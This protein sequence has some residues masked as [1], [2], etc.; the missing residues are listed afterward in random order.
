MKQRIYVVS[1]SVGETCELVVRAAAIQFPEQAFE[2]VRIPFVDDEQVIFDLVLH[3]KEERAT[4]VYT[5][6][7]AVHRKVLEETARAHHVEAIDVLGPLLDSMETRLGLQP[8]EEPG[9]IYRLDEEYFRKIEAVEFAVKYDD[10]RDPRGIKR[11]DI[12]LIGVS[13]TSKTPLSQYLALKRYKVANVPLVPESIPPQ[14]LFEIPKEKCFGLLISPEKL[15]DIRMERLRSLGLKP[16][17]AYAQMDRINRELEY[18]RNLYER[19]GCQV[20]DVTNKAVEETANLILTGIS[21]R[22]HE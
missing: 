18:A 4:I 21:G 8:K 14:E 2:T 22:T 13:R 17:A 1:D 12:V 9:L 5:I 16:E 19:I 7:H 10:G 3:A 6:V 15:I 20:I 11:A